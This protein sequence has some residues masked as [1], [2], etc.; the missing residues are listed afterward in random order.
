M[1]ALVISGAYL[2]LAGLVWAVDGRPTDWM[3]LAFFFLIFTFGELFI[4]PTGLGLFA[5]LAPTHLGAT[6]VGT[7]FLIIFTGSLSAG[8]VGTLWSSLHHAV[9]FAL[10]AALA[11]LAAA[12]LALLNA[13]TQRLERIRR[14]AAKIS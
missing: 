7:W 3:W 14:A 13:P 6:T 12:L 10:L 4:L 9:F 8:L 5:R 11:A 1:G 2:L